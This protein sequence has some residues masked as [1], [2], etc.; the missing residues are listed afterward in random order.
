MKQ[1]ENL[2]KLG[3]RMTRTVRENSRWIH[4][5]ITEEPGNLQESAPLKTSQQDQMYQD[6]AIYMKTR[7]EELTKTNDGEHCEL[8]DRLTRAYSPQTMTEWKIIQR[9]VRY[10]L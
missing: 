6:L 4:I 5:R 8:R 9:Y 10:G 7:R 2:K 1:T 3:T